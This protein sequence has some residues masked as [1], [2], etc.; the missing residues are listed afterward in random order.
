MLLV[1]AHVKLH[2]DDAAEDIA[3]AVG[4]DVA[5]VTMLLDELEVE[6]MIVA[7]AGRA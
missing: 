6:G 7:A 2:P 5:E 1:L 4:L 3:L